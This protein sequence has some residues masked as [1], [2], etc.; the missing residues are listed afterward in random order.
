MKG[1]SPRSLVLWLGVYGGAT[2]LVFGAYHLCRFYSARCSVAFDAAGL[3]SDALTAYFTAL[4][5]V[6]LV[7]STVYQAR[8]NT[9][10]QQSLQT[11]NQKNLRLQHDLMW[12]RVQFARME[13]FGQ[14]DPSR[15]LTRQ[16]IESHWGRLSAEIENELKGVSKNVSK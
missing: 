5:F 16:Q 11:E 8:S 13:S 6:G 3:D 1:T 9:A 10:A 2:T 14:D 7:V 4:A 15:A 12:F